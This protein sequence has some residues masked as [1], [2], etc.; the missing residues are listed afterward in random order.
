MTKLQLKAQLGPSLRHNDADD[1]KGLKYKRRALAVLA[2]I[3]FCLSI[4]A[5]AVIT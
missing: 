3:L 5:L 1:G 2:M 4:I